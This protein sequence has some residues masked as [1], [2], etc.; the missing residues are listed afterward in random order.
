MEAILSGIADAVTAQAPDG[1]LLFAND[2]AVTLLGYD[3]AEALMS[4]PLNEIM[5]QYDILD[6]RGEPFPPEAL[7]GTARARRRG[8][9]RHDRPLPG[10]RHGR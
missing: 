9:R 5:S 4:A 10:P 7:P 8:Q 3:S 6:E 2:A 1:H